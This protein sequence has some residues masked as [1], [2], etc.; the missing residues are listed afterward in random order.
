MLSAPTGCSTFI[1][2]L[3]VTPIVPATDTRPRWLPNEGSTNNDGLNLMKV[4]RTLQLQP[5]TSKSKKISMNYVKLICLW[6]HALV[7]K[8]NRNKSKSEV[9]M[10][11]A[12]FSHIMFEPS[13]IVDNVI[14]I[15][16]HW[17]SKEEI[18]STSIPR[19]S[20]TSFY[21]RNFS[22]HGGTAIF[23]KDQIKFSEVGLNE[24]IALSEDKEFE[25]SMV[26]LPEL[27]YIIINVY[28]APSSN[29]P[30]F[31]TKLEVLLNSV[32]SLNMRIILCGDF[33]ID[34]SKNSSAK[35]DLLNMTKSFNMIPT[36]LSPR[37]STEHTDSIIDQIFITDTCYKFTG[38]VL[39]M[40]YSDHDAQLLSVDMENSK[41]SPKKVFQRRNFSDG[42]IRIFNFLLAKENWDRVYMQTTVDNMFL[43]FHNT[44]LYY[45]NTAFP[46]ETKTSSNQNRKLWV[47]KGIKIS[48]ERNRFLQYCSKKYIVTEEFS[49]YCKAYKK[50]YLRVIRQAKLLWNDNFIRN[51][52]NKMKA[53]W[54]A[55]KKETCSST[56]KKENISLTLNDSKGTDPYTVVNKFNE[57][58]TSLADH[59]IQANCKVS[60]FNSTNTPNSTNATMFVY[61]TNPDKIMNIIKLLRN[62]ISSGYDEVPDLILKVCA[63]HIVKPLSTIYNQSLKTGIFPDALKIAKV[64]PLL[65]KGSPDLVSNYRPLSILSIFSKILEKL[66]YDKLVV[67][68]TAIFELLDHIL[69]SIDQHNI[70][71]ETILF[72]REYLS[73]TGKL[74]QN[75]D[76]HAHYTRG[77]SNIH[78]IFSRTSSYQKYITHLGVVLHNKIPEQIKSAPDPIFKN[79]LKAFLTKHCFYSVQ[80]FLEMKNYKV[81]FSTTLPTC[82]LVPHVN[83]LYSLYVKLLYSSMNNF[84][85]SILNF[86]MCK[87]NIRV[88]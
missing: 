19:Y 80:Q 5:G 54:K 79:K 30:N 29:I 44:F 71:A 68:V 75:N 6:A 33:N 57:Y 50:T 3:S 65:K 85:N 62:K 45:L 59:L 22:T 74:I 69:K 28:R 20:L 64:S 51:S 47:T 40:G 56:P 76:I 52:S 35:L 25:L 34:L 61:E 70:A 49:D 21:C 12:G 48:S 23:V 67:V 55:I 88:C 37:R 58:F 14:C 32:S 17:L 86:H 84:V 4:R 2:L 66:F 82:F 7:N 31:M 8:M 73:R 41:I 46:F 1:G 83:C 13:E 77:Q 18:Q 81:P 53:M 38:E 42:N 15:T 10:E 27:N 43:S 63:P 87:P 72:T 78:Q 36:I 24:Q 39:S 16:E 26:K 60:F 11:A 9:E